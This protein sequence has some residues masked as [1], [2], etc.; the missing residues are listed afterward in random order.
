MSRRYEERKRERE[1]C[2]EEREI[3]HLLSSV[4]LDTECI[5]TNWTSSAPISFTT[6][7]NDVN[8]MVSS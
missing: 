2:R 3:F 6:F 5:D 1:R 8:S 7:R 4:A